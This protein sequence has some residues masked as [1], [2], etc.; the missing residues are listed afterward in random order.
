MF[1]SACFVFFVVQV[2]AAITAYSVEYKGLSFNSAFSYLEISR[3]WSDLNNLEAVPNSTKKLVID[4]DGGADDA[5][6]ITM[7]LLNEKYFNGPKVIALT[8][9]FGNVN[10][11]QTII[12]TDRILAL[13]DRHDVPIYS[14]ANK[15]LIANVTSDYFFGYDGLGDDG[16]KPPKPIVIQNESAAVGL[17]EL[18]KK[19]EGELVIV[20]IGPLT[21]IALAARLDPNFIGRLAQL[22]VGAGNIYSDAH[23]YPQFNANMDPEA[24]HIV[25]H[26][27]LIDKVTFVPSSQIHLM[28]N[29]TLDWRKYVLGK[30]DTPLMKALN[31]F[32]RISLPKMH[33]WNVLDPA[34]AAVALVQDLVV[35]FR[36]TK[37]D[38]ILEG[39]LRGT[40]T[41][42]FSSK[43]P[44][45]RMFWVAANEKYKKFLVDVNS[46]E[47]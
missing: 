37:N 10:L 5:F 43:N 30:I 33:V 47:L 42:D 25:A 16:Y 4:H 18:S 36:N 11:T 24:Y 12:N 29:E 26:S 40:N 41:N 22:Y 17:L 28:L 1:L 23:P 35:K 6:A 21:N 38:I 14:G 15:A 39:N 44:N 32:E 19:Y 45:G 2:I 34:V 27:A 13:C 7:S 3:P 31:G 20:A 9:A 8:T 46:A